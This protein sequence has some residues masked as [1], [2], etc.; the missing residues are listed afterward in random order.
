MSDLDRE[1]TAPPAAAS[2][3]D[4]GT[5]VVHVGD[6]EI[7]IE[8]VGGG[9]WTLPVGATTLV[10]GPLERADRPRPEQLTNALG[11]V[12]DQF[13]DVIIEA[14]IVASAPALVFQG[15]HAL[16]VAR[17]ELGLDAVPEDYVL[18]RADA[19]E[20]FRTIVAEPRAERIHNPGL[21]AAAVD[22]VIAGCCALLAFLRRLD[23]Q[24]ARVVA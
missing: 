9:S 10:E 22:T 4:A 11:A 19:D 17:V 14:P 21:D 23:R 18:H 2:G 15:P 24:H 8:M 3:F 16:M 5:L 12:A 1:P 6:T 13:D 20:V 7:A